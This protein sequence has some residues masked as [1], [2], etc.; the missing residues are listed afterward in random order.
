MMNLN[1]RT[2]AGKQKGKINDTIKLLLF[3]IP[4]GT[5]KCLYLCRRDVTIFATIFV[6]FYTHD[7]DDDDDVFSFLLILK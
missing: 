1:F 2:C 6:V 5:K 4:S 3:K 7:D